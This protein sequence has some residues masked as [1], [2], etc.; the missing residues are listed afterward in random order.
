MPIIMMIITE[1]NCG[2][3][4]DINKHFSY[5]T[6]TDKNEK[7]LINCISRLAL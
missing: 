1:E 5:N 4:R 2:D 3:E 7:G 6:M